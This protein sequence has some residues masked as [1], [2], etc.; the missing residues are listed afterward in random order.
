MGKSNFFHKLVVDYGYWLDLFNI[1]LEN[2]IAFCFP[3][4]LCYILIIENHY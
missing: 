1:S 2:S 4:E 3:N